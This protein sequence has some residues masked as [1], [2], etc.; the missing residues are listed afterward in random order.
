[1]GILSS[2]A[3]WLFGEYS[4]YF[5]YR[6]QSGG[7]GEV[8]ISDQL[9]RPTANELLRS[10]RTLLAEQ[11]WYLGSG[12]DAFAMADEAGIAAVCFY[13]HG[14]RYKQRGFWPLSPGEAKL[15][16]IVVDPSARGKGLA[17]QLIEASA[18][19]MRQQGWQSLY[20]R[21]WHSNKPSLLAFE[22][23]AW[24]RIAIVA[25]LY[26]MGSKRK[27]RI[28]IPLSRSGQS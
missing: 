18:A 3:R 13:W 28:Q 15:V 25:E 7:Q 27:L 4:L 2:C 24:Q 5:V 12:C 20:A 26:P 21:I 16:Q 1:M 19:S 23:A 9:L 17:K 22:R 6:W 14:E 10:E 11:A 8:S